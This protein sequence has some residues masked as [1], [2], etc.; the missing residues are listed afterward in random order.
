MGVSRNCPHCDK[1]FRVSSD[2]I[3][4][5]STTPP[6]SFVYKCPHCGKEI[7]AQMGTNE[8]EE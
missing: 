3:R 4:V 5:I 2:E 8:K 1:F 7:L 6:A